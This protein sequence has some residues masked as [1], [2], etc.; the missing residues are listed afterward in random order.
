MCY[1]LFETLQLAKYLYNTYSIHEQFIS[2]QAILNHNIQSF[3]YLYKT[4]NLVIIVLV[5]VIGL[6]HH[7]I[8]PDHS[9]CPRLAY[10]INDL[11]F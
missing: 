10:V 7:D 6:T 9:N 8:K 4:F 2:L 11:L 3:V 1:F 5:I